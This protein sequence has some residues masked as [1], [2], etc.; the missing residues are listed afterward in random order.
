MSQNTTDEFFKT[1]F[2]D[3]LQDCSCCF[4]LKCGNDFL[5]MECVL[6]LFCFNIVPCKGAGMGRCHGLYGTYTMWVY[7]TPVMEFLADRYLGYRWAVVLGALAMTLGHASMAVETPC[8][9]Y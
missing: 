9:L 4:L 3:T 6:Y 5:I 7:F 2:L 8:F 1:L